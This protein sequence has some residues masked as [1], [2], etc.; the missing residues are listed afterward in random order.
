MRRCKS[1]E[2]NVLFPSMTHAAL[3][4]CLTKKSLIM[5]KHAHAGSNGCKKNKEYKI[6]QDSKTKEKEYALHR[7]FLKA[8]SLVSITWAQ[9]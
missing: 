5:K 8:M 2:Y 3:T 7:A 1:Q 4:M 6:I 9:A